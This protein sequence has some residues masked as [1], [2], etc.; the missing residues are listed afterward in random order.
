MLSRFT[1]ALSQLYQ[2]LPLE[3]AAPTFKKCHFPVPASSVSAEFW[4]LMPHLHDSRPFNELG[5]IFAKLYKDV[6]H[7]KWRFD[8]DELTA[9]RSM[10]SSRQEGKCLSTQ[11]C[12]SAYLVT[13][14]NHNTS[15]PIQ[16]VRNASSV[17]W[18]VCSTEL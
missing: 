11:D 8:T 13:V 16:N 5:E 1:H 7:L 10:L 9:L 17:S 3:H 2:D 6:E 15:T 12:L 14:L 4:P 18:L